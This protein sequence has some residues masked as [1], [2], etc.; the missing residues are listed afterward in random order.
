MGNAAIE[1]H[2]FDLF[3]RDFSLPG[4][5]VVFGD[6]PDVI[7]QSD[8]T[9][10][11]EI[12]RL[13]ISSGQDPSSEQRQKARRA[14]TI[15]I[16]QRLYRDAGGKKFEWTFAFDPTHP[17]LDVVDVANRLRDLAHSTDAMETGALK[18]S[19]HASV[20]ELGFAYLNAREYEDARWRIAQP[21]TVP[22]LHHG[23]VREIASSKD[24]LLSGYAQ[25]D[26]YWLLLVVDYLDPAQ[27]LD[28][29][30]GANESPVITLFDRLF[31]YRT[32]RRE[33]T[34]VPVTRAA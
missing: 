27:D 23:R 6:K 20:P 14:E 24:V 2:Y 25:C 10:G 5:D 17:I 32:L 19:A 30:W 34:E 33:V 12:A 15:E 16:A 22:D 8:K 29:T 26:N 31:I 11:I 21:H 18:R 3:G 9:V 7:L 13:Y 28:I 4:G 1:R